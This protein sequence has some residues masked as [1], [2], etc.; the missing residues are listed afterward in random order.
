M[1]S[2]R[3]QKLIVGVFTI[4]AFTALLTF[5]NNPQSQ[6]T[7]TGA[8]VFTPANSLPPDEL[9]ARAKVNA[10][11]SRSYA[12]PV[13]AGVTT[14]KKWSEIPFRTRLL[15]TLAVG[16]IVTFGTIFLIGHYLIES[17]FTHRRR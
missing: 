16:L 2:S 5:A 13:V 7:L 6:K 3:F 8:T 17:D 11:V 1:A 9:L 4:L 14:T 10:A 12:K 15:I